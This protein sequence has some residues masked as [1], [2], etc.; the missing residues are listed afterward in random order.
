MKAVCAIR[1]QPHYRREAFVAGLRRAGYS[2]VDRAPGPDG[3]DDALVIWNRYGSFERQA[4]DWE[5]KGGMVI[6]AEN[7]YLGRDSEGRQ[8]Y[9]LSVHGH[10]GSGW[11]PVGSEH[12][13]AA[14]GVEVKP[15]RQTGE[16]IVVRGQRG[17]GTAQMR[18]PPDWH[19]G[20]KR[21]LGSLTRRPVR[22]IEH[23]GRKPYERPFEEEL[24]GAWACAIW[25]SA[26]GVLAL[27]SGI[28]VLCE[29]PSWICKAAASPHLEDAAQPLMDDELR[30]AA[31][32]RMAHG[33]WSVAEIETG[34]PFAR[35]LAH[36]AEATWQ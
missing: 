27:V 33:Q 11:F 18:S 22:V 35:F 5:A 2:V 14:L 17:I 9:A 13:F 30:R 36:H 24:V 12:R 20:A 10:N 1:S 26:V 16:H 23:P 25:A 4:D 3:P 6:V 19:Q 29:A 34:E 7:G 8:L 21:R 31:L 28:P 15:W 32:H